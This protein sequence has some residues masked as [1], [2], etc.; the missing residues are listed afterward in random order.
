[1]KP[2]IAVVGQGWNNQVK[3]SLTFLPTNFAKVFDALVYK[4][5]GHFS[6]T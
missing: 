6:T 4:L 3:K 5:S 2:R 1:M